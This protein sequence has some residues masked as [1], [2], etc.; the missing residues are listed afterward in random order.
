MADAEV[1][2]W[3][4]IKPGHR[5]LGRDDREIGTVHRVLADDGAGIFHGVSLRRGLLGREVEI[6]ADRI[7]RITTGY[8]H[9]DV[10]P[11][12]VESLPVPRGG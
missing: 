8:L 4:A 9:T 7:D 11:D 1:V 3:T 2:A 6:T 12:Q 5:I 10:E